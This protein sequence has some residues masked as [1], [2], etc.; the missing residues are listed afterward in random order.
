MWKRKFIGCIFMS[1]EY[2]IICD[3]IIPPAIKEV[4]LDQSDGSTVE[5]QEN[6]K[7]AVHTRVREEPEKS[8]GPSYSVYI[9]DREIRVSVHSAVF[10]ADTRAAY[11]TLQ[12]FMDSGISFQIEEL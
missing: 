2:R 10:Y 8:E 4:F 5:Y 9:E 11:L 1:V 3:E 7:V 6:G 12:A